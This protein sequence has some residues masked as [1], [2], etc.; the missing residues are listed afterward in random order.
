[1]TSARA[2]RRF[3]PSRW[4]KLTTRQMDAW[5]L[6]GTGVK[7]MYGGCRGGG[8]S[9]FCLRAAW[10]VACQFPAIRVVLVRKSYPELEDVFITRFVDNFPSQHGSQEVYRYKQKEK[11]ATFWNQSR[12]IFRAVENEQDA[13][14]LQGAECQLLIVDEAVNFEE[15]TFLRLLGSLRG[16]AG[17]GFKP[18]VVYTGNPGGVSDLYFITRFVEPDY[19]RWSADELKEKDNY[20]YI[21]ATVYDN[22]FVDQGYVARL[23]SLPD[24]LRRAW[25][26]GEWGNFSGQFF[27]TWSRSRHVIEPFEIPSGWRKVG[28]IDLGYNAHPTVA[29]WLTQ[30]PD[31][32]RVY[33]YR[34]YADTGPTEHHVLQVRAWQP[35][36]EA[37]ELFYGD[38]SMFHDGKKEKYESESPARMFLMGG[39]PL[40][41]ANNNRSIGWLVLKQWLESPPGGGAP[42]LRVFST[43]TYLIDT[44]PRQRYSSGRNNQ[45]REDLDTRGPDDGVDALRYGIVSGFG[46]P[47]HITESSDEIEEITPVPRRDEQSTWDSNAVSPAANFE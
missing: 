28:C 10:L 44:F 30:N 16:R 12:I 39:V 4:A 47:P 33:V 6:I 13:E 5:R 34:E 19:A 8:K 42:M 20:H 35:E 43:C 17:S 24:D 1:M 14:K 21:H 22:P 41:P 7:L 45:K 36:T 32:C 27:S 23:E 26:Y 11:T 31:D 9:E 2:S 18:T 29:L 15:R 25:L 37:V 40:L 3:S 38:P 46:Y